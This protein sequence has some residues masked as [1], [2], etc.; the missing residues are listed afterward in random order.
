M[1]IRDTQLTH[2]AYDPKYGPRRP[3]L[4]LIWHEDGRDEITDGARCEV[5]GC[6]DACTAHSL[7][8][9]HEVGVEGGGDGQVDEAS[10][11]EEGEDQAVQLV[12]VVPTGE[13]QKAADIL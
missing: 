11:Q 10:V 12:G 13:R 9:G 2:N 3:T 4:A 5:D 7:N 6:E 8:V 1:K